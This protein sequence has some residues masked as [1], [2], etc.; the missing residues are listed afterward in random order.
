MY[1]WQKKQRLIEELDSK[2]IDVSYNIGNMFQEKL[3]ACLKSKHPRMEFV[4]CD[5][6]TELRETMVIEKKRSISFKSARASRLSADEV[7]ERV[8]NE[9]T[10][11]MVRDISS[12]LDGSMKKCYVASQIWCNKKNL[13]TPKIE[14]YVEFFQQ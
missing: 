8:V 10:Q 6:D 12:K 5:C 14:A 3:H 1:Q 7:V 2:W 4:I 9:I 11:E 13:I